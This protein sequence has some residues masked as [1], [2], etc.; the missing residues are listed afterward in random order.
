[1]S[2]T[3]LHSSVV[4][5]KRQSFFS[6]NAA[7]PTLDRSNFVETYQV[8]SNE[9]VRL[10]CPIFATP[11]PHI[12][13]LINNQ[14]LLPITNSIEKNID[15]YELANENRTLIIANANAHDNG[16]YT[17]IGRNIIGELRSHI[18]LQMLG[19]YPPAVDKFILRYTNVSIFLVLPIIQRDP[20][21][22]DVNVIQHHHVALS[23]TATGLL[24]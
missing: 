8:K 2:Q 12:R 20:N 3:P 17:C 4:S 19:L 18:D 15:R 11:Q 10:E 9:T 7:P 14:D 16:R 24:R 13:W 22:I 5:G 1:M 6:I 21:Q 23:C